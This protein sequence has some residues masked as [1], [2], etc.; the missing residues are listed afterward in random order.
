MALPAA[1]AAIL[2]RMT[3]PIDPK[4]LRVSD[5][6]RTHVLVLLERA[7]GSGLLNVHEYASRSA[8]VVAARTRGELNAVLV[9][10]PGLQIAGRTVGQAAA[11]TAPPPHGP[12]FSG[13]VGTPRASASDVLDLSGWGSRTFRGSWI[14][15]SLILVSG[16]GA[17]TKLDFTQ[18]TL[19]SPVVTVEFR[20][21]YGG[22]ADL[23]VPAGTPVRLDGLQMR[24]GQLNNKL[25]PGPPHG[26]FE[27]TL[28]GVKKHGSVTIRSPKQSRW[29]R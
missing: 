21:N 16:T 11:A 24:G 9:D 27:L 7:T 12:G 5:A 28:S 6:E 10:L 29:L 18:A 3:Q 26:R 19:T 22:A 20:G 4:D 2:A 25:R 1:P 8:A 13:A 14:V 17:S 23:I 15:P